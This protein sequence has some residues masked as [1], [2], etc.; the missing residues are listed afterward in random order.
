[1]PSHTYHGEE[2]ARLGNSCQ[3]PAEVCWR[4]RANEGL[5]NEELVQVNLG[6]RQ[7]PPQRTLFQAAPVPEHLAPQYVTTPGFA[8]FSV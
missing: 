3:Y 5:G 6:T 4:Y 2:I 8:C 7:K 1:M